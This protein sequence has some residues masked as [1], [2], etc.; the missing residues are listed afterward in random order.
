MI[1]NLNSQIA[2]YYRE[3]IKVEEFVGVVGGSKLEACF[4]G[5]EG[6]DGSVRILLLSLLSSFF[7]FFLLRANFRPFPSSPIMRLRYKR[8]LLIFLHKFDVI[9]LSTFTIK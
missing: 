2:P 3:L 7:F 4:E 6:R 9:Y 8:K 1:L 5:D